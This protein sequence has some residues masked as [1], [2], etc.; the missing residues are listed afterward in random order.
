MIADGAQNRKYLV[1][2]NEE[3]DYF[4]LHVPSSVWVQHRPESE[5]LDLAYIYRFVKWDCHHLD[6]IHFPLESVIHV[7]YRPGA[8][9]SKID[10]HVEVNIRSLN[11]QGQR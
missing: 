11:K 9:I 4:R 6:S 1:L 8:A 3:N 7:P 2:I 10:I 5:A